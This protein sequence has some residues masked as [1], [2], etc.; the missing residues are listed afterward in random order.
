MKK[1]LML[2][3]F[4]NEETIHRVKRKCYKPHGKGSSG[5]IKYTLE[6]CTKCNR[7]WY[8]GKLKDA[9]MPQQK[10]KKHLKI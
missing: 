6:H 3:R 5:G 2:C 9:V 8:N 7:R 4:C 1:K 10:K